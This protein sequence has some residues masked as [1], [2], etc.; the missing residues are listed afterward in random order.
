MK[1]KIT[2]HCHDIVNRYL[3]RE[4]VIVKIFWLDKIQFILE[5]YFGTC[6]RFINSP[7]KDIIISESEKSETLLEEHL[8]YQGL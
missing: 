1:T 5:Q 6:K 7:R 4:G 3:G 2:S 8:P